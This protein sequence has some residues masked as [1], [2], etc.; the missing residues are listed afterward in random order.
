[1]EIEQIRALLPGA[2]GSVIGRTFARMSAAE[3]EIR[4]AKARHPQHAPQIDKAFGILCPSAPLQHKSVD[5][6][7]AHCRELLDRVA[8]DG[9]T[10]AAT[11]AEVLCAVLD[12]SLKAPITTTA[13]ALAEQLFERVLDGAPASR[14]PE[15]WPGACDELRSQIAR[16][17]ADPERRGG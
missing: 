13:Q 6:Y 16:R 3:E 12:Q 17:L 1:M 9:D 15:P 4:D 14:T 2:V 8:I 10:R 5:V 11:D 7:R